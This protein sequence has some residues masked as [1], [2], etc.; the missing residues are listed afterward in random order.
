MDSQPQDPPPSVNATVAFGAGEWKFRANISVPAGPTRLRQMLPL[1]QTLSDSMV[2]AVSQD[3][4][5]QGHQVS[6]KKGCG[7]CCRQM[8]P[9]SRV[10]A[11]YLWDL[12]QKLPEPRRSEVRARF[13][14]ALGRLAES[15]LLEKMRHCDQWSDEDY[16]AIG[17]EYFQQG[18]PCPFL[19]E[20]SCS[21][22]PDRPV[23]C[24]EYL[25]TSPAESC[26]QPFSG[27]VR[28]IPFPFKMWWALARFDPLPADTRYV[29]WVPLV[30]ALQWTEEHPEEDVSQPGPELLAQLFGRLTGKAVQAPPLPL[31]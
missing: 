6:C 4:Q 20:E 21:I 1:V 2:N 26:A 3:V 22:H 17:R 31:T 11:R 28:T 15:G 7:A 23:S 16:R 29:P 13:A 24:R 5:K 25:V 10:E 12:V 14:E 27:G 18:I 19:E 30:L 8:V 9:L